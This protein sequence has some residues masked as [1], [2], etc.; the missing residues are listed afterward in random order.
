MI[1]II[2]KRLRLNGRSQPLDERPLAAER[3]L[4]PAIAPLRATRRARSRKM[5]SLLRNCR[6][7]AARDSPASEAMSSI[8]VRLKP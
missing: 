5:S 4:G 8:E 2:R 1:S 6:Y 3:C 7:S